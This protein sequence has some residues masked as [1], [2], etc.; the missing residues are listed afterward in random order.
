M[1]HDKI[2]AVSRE[3]V[4]YLERIFPNRCPSITDTNRAIWMAVGHQD[5]I[6]KLRSL[7][8]QQSKSVSESSL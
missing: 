6:R 1:A 3:L 2:P 8:E 4:E 7:Y 5:V